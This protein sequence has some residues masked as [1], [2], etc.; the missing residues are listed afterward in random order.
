MRPTEFEHRVGAEDEI[1][2][3]PPRLAHV[4]VHA[5]TGLNGEAHVLG[6][7]EAREEVGELE[8]APEAASR[9]QRGAEPRHVLPL[10]Q[11]RAVRGGELPRHEVEVGRLAGAV[12]PDDGG[13]LAGPEGA[14]DVVDRNVAAEADGQVPRLERRGHR[15]L[16]IGMSMSSILS[17]RVSSSTAHGS[18]GS[19]LTLKAYIDCSA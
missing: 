7:A 13:E 2:P 4:V 18:F 11:D 6:D 16:R 14:G 3:R 15:L 9:A 17:S 1:H 8:G 12:G 10:D 19:T 5:G